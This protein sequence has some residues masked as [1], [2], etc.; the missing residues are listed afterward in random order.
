MTGVRLVLVAVL[1]LVG[2]GFIVGGGA[3]LHEQYRKDR[4]ILASPYP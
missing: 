3:K 4:A 1:T 2:A